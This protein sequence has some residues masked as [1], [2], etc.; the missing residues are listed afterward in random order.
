[1]QSTSHAKGLTII[2]MLLLVFLQYR[3]WFESDGIIDMM[4]VKRQLALEA[5]QNE[6]LKKRNEILIRQIQNLQTSNVAVEARARGEL[7]MVKRGETFYQV[8]N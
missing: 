1:M 3:L 4:R 7:G 5:V 2:L 8:V 6:K